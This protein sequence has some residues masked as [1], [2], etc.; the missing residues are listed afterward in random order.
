MSYKSALY[1]F[2]NTYSYGHYNRNILLPPPPPLDGVVAALTPVVGPAPVAGA[3]GVPEGEVAPCGA[4][5]C[6]VPEGEVVA[7]V[8]PL[9][10]VAPPPPIP[11]VGGADVVG[12]PGP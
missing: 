4:V 12:T 6:G 8:A 9:G 10:P 3:V 1:L 2:N 11:V 7:C 5:T